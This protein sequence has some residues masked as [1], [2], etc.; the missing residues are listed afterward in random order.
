MS[1]GQKQGNRADDTESQNNVVLTTP[2]T[3]ILNNY[4]NH[5]EPVLKHD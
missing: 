1:K 2:E 5:F 4:C 3:L